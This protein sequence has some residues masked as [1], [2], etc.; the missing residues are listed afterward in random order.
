M[1]RWPFFWQAQDCGA[2]VSLLLWGSTMSNVLRRTLV[3]PRTLM[4]RARN[5]RP[6]FD[7]ET[8]RVEV[9][10]LPRAESVRA[11]TTVCCMRPLWIPWVGEMS[12][13]R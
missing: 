2:V 5:H 1:G 8:R 7:G 11:L 10:S 4:R 9:A 6:A 3:S 12:Q 13:D